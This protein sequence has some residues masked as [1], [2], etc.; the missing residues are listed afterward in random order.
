MPMNIRPRMTPSAAADCVKAPAEKC[1]THYDNKRRA[2]HGPKAPQ[3]ANP[4]GL[5]V[6][7]TLSA[8]KEALKN[9]AVEV[10]LPDWYAAARAK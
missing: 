3:R 5:T 6:P 1:V 7:Q 8:F 9:D 10:R 2:I 4:G